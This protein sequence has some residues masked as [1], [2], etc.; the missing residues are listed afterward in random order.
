M[1][2]EEVALILGEAKRYTDSQRLAY[3]SKP[4]YTFNGDTTGK[5]QVEE[6]IKISD[7]TPDLTQITKVVAFGQDGFHGEITGDDLTITNQSSNGWDEQDARIGEQIFI[8]VIS[9][10]SYELVPN[11]LYVLSLDSG[12]ISKIEFSETI[13]P[14]PAEYIPP[15]DHLILNG[16]DGKQYKL[17]VDESGALTTTEVV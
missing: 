9:N 17:T 15:L 6:Y 10:S 11:G 2:P 13:H 8:I 5:V 1:K 16:L 14:I 3:S 7:D 12:Y 4:V